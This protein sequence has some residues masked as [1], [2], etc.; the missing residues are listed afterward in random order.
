MASI[1]FQLGSVDSGVSKMRSEVIRPM[2][3]QEKKLLVE[4]I[5]KLSKEAHLEIHNLLKKYT[6]NYTVTRNGVFFNLGGFPDIVLREL[7]RMTDFYSENEKKLNLTQKDKRDIS[8]YKEE[9]EEVENKE[10]S[11]VS[12]KEDNTSV[13]E[14]SETEVEPLPPPSPKKKTK[15]KTKS[16]VKA[17]VTKIVKTE[18][19]KKTK[20]TK[21]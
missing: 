13:S 11:P 20:K 7:S 21:Q 4:R 12:S 8:L 9:V 10:L 5:G 14:S 18:T 1:H 17:K 6:P 19:T 3:F 15:T 16:T 2:S